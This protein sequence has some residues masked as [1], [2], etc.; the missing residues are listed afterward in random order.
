M[1]IIWYNVSNERIKMFYFAQISLSLRAVHG[2]GIQIYD[3]KFE[4]IIMGGQY[5]PSPYGELILKNFCMEI[6]YMLTDTLKP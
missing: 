1:P 5:P 3:L 6:L 4:Y 2:T